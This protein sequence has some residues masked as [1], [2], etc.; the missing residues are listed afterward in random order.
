MW[1]AWIL[2]R[3]ERLSPGR[4]LC[5]A[6]GGGAKINE[7]C[8][9][10]NNCNA[11]YWNSPWT[12]WH[13][14]LQ[15]SYMGVF[16]AN[17]SICSGQV[18]RTRA[19]V[20]RDLLLDRLFGYWQAGSFGNVQGPSSPLPRLFNMAFHLIFACSSTQK[21]RSANNS[22]KWNASL[23]AT[24]ASCPPLLWNAKNHLFVC[25]ICLIRPRISLQARVLGF[26]FS[27]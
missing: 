22:L 6:E 9:A 7:P 13:F 14:P 11:I 26:S 5:R 25:F 10:S 17:R 21:F 18:S 8:Y 1:V 23:T 24:A 19:A 15:N 3:L 12:S 4:E 20:T 27:N 2:R 16:V